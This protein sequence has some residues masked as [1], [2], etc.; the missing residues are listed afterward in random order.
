MIRDG[1]AITFEVNGIP[2]EQIRRLR[3]DGVSAL[4]PESDVV[5]FEFW[6]DAYRYMRLPSRALHLVA[7]GKGVLAERLFWVRPRDA[8][9]ASQSLLTLFLH[10]SKTGGTAIRRSMETIAAAASPIYQGILPAYYMPHV[11]DLTPE[12]VSHFDFVFGHLW[13]GAHQIAKGRPYIYLTVLREPYAFLES[14][15]FYQKYAVG[16]ITHHSIFDFLAD[17]EYKNETDNHFVRMLSGRPRGRDPLTTEDL[18][19]AIANI[20]RD[21]AFV[22]IAE[23]MTGTLQQLSVITGFDLRSTGRENVTPPSE[24]RQTLDRSAFASAAGELVKYDLEV[25]RYVKAKFFQSR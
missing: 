23:D 6:I 18:Q 14:L 24:E 25:Y 3:R 15:Y 13:Y 19:L 2:V 7:R 21:F 20:D 12:T 22:G 8:V 16:A 17:I 10:M 11:L 9:E 4:Y 1:S 5:G